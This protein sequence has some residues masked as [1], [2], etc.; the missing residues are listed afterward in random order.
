[1]FGEHTITVLIGSAFLM[2]MTGY[3]ITLWR[4]KGFR[5]MKNRGMYLTGILA[6]L[7]AVGIDFSY[8]LMVSLGMDPSPAIHSAVA[9][10]LMV[11]I[12]IRLMTWRQFKKD[13]KEDFV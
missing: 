10:L 7:M 4:T 12:Y 13:V 9:P 5:G 1:M 2:L 11:G 3:G 6:V 8:H